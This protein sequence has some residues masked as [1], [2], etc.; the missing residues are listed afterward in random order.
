MV[1]EASIRWVR[2][3]RLA[4]VLGVTVGTGSDA[5]AASARATGSPELTGQERRALDAVLRVIR[6]W[7][8]GTGPCLRESLVLGHL[9]RVREPMLRFGVARE[10]GRLRAHAWIEIGDRPINDPQGFVPLRGAPG[11]R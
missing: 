6:C 11:L 5:F 1:V 7:P 9:L 4:R 8:F 2:V 10:R 3:P